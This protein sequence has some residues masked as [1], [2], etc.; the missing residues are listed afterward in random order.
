MLPFFIEWGTDSIHPSRDAPPGC[1]LERFVIAG[2]NPAELSSTFER[3]G[4]DVAVER[5][6]RIQLRARITGPKGALEVTS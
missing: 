4:V 5:A 2:P 1:R 6:G 3:L